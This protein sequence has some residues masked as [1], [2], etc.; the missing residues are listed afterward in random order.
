MGVPAIR[1]IGAARLQQA[2]VVMTGAGWIQPC[3]SAAREAERRA[4]AAAFN[5]AVRARALASAEITVQAAA[6][7]GSGVTVDRVGQLFLRALSG[8]ADDPAE[9]VTRILRAQGEKMVKDG[10][11]LET[12]EENAA[13]IARRWA[14]FVA[15]QLPRLSRIGAFDAPAG[16]ARPTGTMD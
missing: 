1:A 6:V 14:D 7:S 5:D 11:V 15:G 12:P 2:L 10:D 16:V 3:G 9:Y 4:G 13:E 8:N